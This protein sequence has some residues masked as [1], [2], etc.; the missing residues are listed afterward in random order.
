MYAGPLE[1]VDWDAMWAQ[2]MSLTSFAG[3][4]VKYWNARAKDFTDTPK[5][6]RYVDEMLNR[7]DLS[8]EC[9]VLDIG[10]GTGAMAIP[11]AKKVQ[12][13]T[14]LDISPVMLDK[15]KTRIASDGLDNIRILN[16]DWPRVKIG[17]DIHPH[18]IVLASRS[19]P[20]GDLRQ[21]LAK[22]D[23]SAKR[24]CYLTWIV[25]GDQ[26]LSEACRILRVEYHPFP[27]YIIMCNM[28]YSMG[29]HANVEIFD[30]L[31][32]R[33]FKDLDEAASELVRG[34]CIENDR[35]RERLKALAQ[36]ELTCEGGCYYR[37]ITMKW[38][39][40]WWRKGQHKP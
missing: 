16:A 14:A 29:I 5:A 21:S 24:L 28:L 39:L 26:I 10:C 1:N 18:D 36:S 19:L 23:A 38:A 25:G 12:R 13:V 22:M 3:D 2:K 30:V 27:D 9:S 32:R 17:I 8:T 35:V 7:M 6:D 34:H 4:G 11:I 31:G 37:D 33:K 40:I 20:M 15:L